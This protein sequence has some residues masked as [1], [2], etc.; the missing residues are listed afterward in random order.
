MR[1]ALARLVP[2]A[3]QEAHP[4]LSKLSFAG[5]SK[6]SRLRPR[7]A[8][9][10][11]SLKEL[12]TLA[13]RLCA[14]HGGTA[15]VLGALSPR[16]RNAQVALFQS[17]EVDYLV[18]TDAIG[19]GL[20]LTLS[21]VAFAS[22]R[23]FDGHKPRSLS[24]AELAQ[25]AGRAGRYLQDGSFGTVLPLELDR[26]IAA[27]VEEHRFDPVRR[28]RYRNSDLDFSSP[29]ALVESLRQAP[30][31]ALLQPVAGATDLR[32]LEA[33]LHGSEVLR[34]LGPPTRL[35]LLWQVCQIPDFRKLLFE[36]HVELLRH[37]F[38]TLARG[39]LDSDFMSG[40]F[41]ELS[42]L[43]GDADTLMARIARLRTWAF[44]ANQAH[45]VSEARHWQGEFRA[46]ED[47]L[48]DALHVALVQRFVERGA[49]KT[50]RAKARPRALKAES[51]MPADAAVFRPFAALSALRG[52]LAAPLE[53]APVEGPREL[54]ELVEAAHDAFTLDA[55]GRVLAGGRMLGNLTRGASLSLPEVRLLELAELGAG[56]RLRLQRRVLAFARDAV[57]RLLAPLRELG[58]SEF[59]SVRAVAYQ[60]EQGLGTALRR[61][62]A[63]TLDQLS[64]EAERE[65]VRGGVELGQVSVLLPALARRESLEQR[66][67]LLRAHQPGIVLPVALGRPCYPVAR[68]STSA[69]LSLGYVPLGSWALR[70]DLA[71]RAASTLA[72]ERE[73]TRVLASLGVPRAERPRV[74]RALLQRVAAPIESRL[75]E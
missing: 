54:I 19:L 24:D 31:S 57:G 23:K 72:E 16:A 5:S 7:S 62:L 39:P 36:G 25:I 17:G 3:Q 73:V 65:L 50:P 9:V 30:K 18:A 34:E 60:L 12:Y 63:P 55:Q 15:V 28:V 51:E 59:G 41:R 43:D 69:W 40:K 66:A 1:D 10:A 52:R 13:G 49:R 32:A 6:L 21:H 68:L 4:R 27:R 58:R 2:A 61:E 67:A 48:S 33:L 75:N 20:N 38:L 64:A 8:L 44:V 29:A 45:F 70:G 71:E 37:V 46:L 42:A 22:L 56:A 53:A 26:A 11:F 74:A 14:L 35:E 47:R